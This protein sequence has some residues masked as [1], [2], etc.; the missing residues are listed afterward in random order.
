[1]SSLGL[2]SFRR[3]VAKLG[4]LLD[5]AREATDRPFLRLGAILQFKFTYELAWRILK[6]HLD[7]S[8]PYEGSVGTRAFPALIRAGSEQGVLRSGWD[9]WKRFRNARGT[10]I[11]AHD[12]EK[13][14]E[15][16][17]VIPAFLDEAVYLLERLEAAG[18]ADA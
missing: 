6:G 13:A 2:A 12:E 16:F 8:A 1:M 10:T 5:E 18:A 11:H 9:A 14:A 15:V 17:A 3:A 7:G 4:E